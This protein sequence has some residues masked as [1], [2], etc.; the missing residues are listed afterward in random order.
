MKTLKMN[1]SDLDIQNNEFALVSEV[2]EVAQTL[3]NLLSIRLGEFGLDEL[4]GLDRTNLLGKPINYDEIRDDVISCLSIDDRVEIVNDIDIKIGNDRSA[5]VRFSVKL[6]GGQDVE[7]EV[8]V[9]A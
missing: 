7:G 2:E 9:D 3:Q 5:A 8:I 6:I 1:G 4:V